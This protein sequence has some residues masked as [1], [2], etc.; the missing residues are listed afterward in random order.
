MSEQT[1]STQ[2]IFL[3]GIAVILAAMVIN[4]INFLIFSSAGVYEGV[5]NA[6]FNAEIGITEVVFS[7]IGQA[8][9]GLIV[10]F[11]IVRFVSNPI[12]IWTI[13][14]WIA[15][16]SSFALPFSLENATTG[17]IISL[18]LMHLTSGLALIYGLPYL[19]KR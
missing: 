19:L 1:F 6:A 10:F 7:S 17:A 8:F 5:I 14:A 15:L 16:I 11:L 4:I 13:L 12:R 2:K 3:Y 9:V 18:N